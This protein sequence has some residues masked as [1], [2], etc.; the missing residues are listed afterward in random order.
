MVTGGAGF[1]GS[2]L[3]DRLLAE[4][5]EVD[6]VDDLSTG[7]LAN[8][9]EARASGGAFRFHNLDIRSADL[10]RPRPPPPAGGD[11][12]PR[13]PGRRC[14]VSRSSGRC[15]MPRS[16]SSARS[17]SAR[18][19]P[20]PQDAQGRLR[21]LRRHPLRR[22]GR[23]RPAG[24]RASAARPAVA[25]RGVEEGGHRLPRRLPRAA[26]RRVHRPR[27]RERLR[28]PPGPARRGRR[29]RHL[30]RQPR[31][32]KAVRDLRRREQTRELRV[33]GRRRRRL[34]T[35]RATRGRARPEHRHRPRDLD[36]ELYEMAAAPPGA[37]LRHG[38][39]RQARRACSEAP[40]TRGGRAFTSAG[41]RGRDL[42]T[43]VAS[44][45]EPRP[46]GRLVI[47]VL[48]GGVG[49]A[50]LLAGLQA[51]VDPGRS[52]AVVNTGDDTELHGLYDQPGPR[53]DH[54]HLWP[55]S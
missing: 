1:I 6:V 20:Q 18:G 28:P 52:V 32:R 40:S 11:L 36:V 34:R 44:V 53:H 47:A 19:R 45:V 31:R 50:R 48:C 43:G 42:A 54:L 22:A 21:R 46:Q 38:R 29:G 33:R 24:R 25:V 7:S 5:H 37:T 35:R 41:N 30:R 13:R 51:V 8:L 12:P 23:R 16:T 10:R 39:H 27:P 15:S 2:T 14:R 49:A 3:V 55:A 4:G 17:R 26:R 9:A